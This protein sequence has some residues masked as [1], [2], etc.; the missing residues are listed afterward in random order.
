[1]TMRQKRALLNRTFMGNVLNVD[2]QELKGEKQ[3][4]ADCIVPAWNDPGA[5]QNPAKYSSNTPTARHMT[6][7]K[8]SELRNG[9][10]LSLIHISE[11]TRP[12]LI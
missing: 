9:H 10:I 7:N 4:I 8:M 5:A 1:M 3:R 6:G 11:P 12:R 2:W